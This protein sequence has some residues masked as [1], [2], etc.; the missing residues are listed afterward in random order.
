MKIKT[1][2]CSNKETVEQ[3]NESMQDKFQSIVLLGGQENYC[4]GNSGLR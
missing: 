2:N 3:F 1:E 4:F